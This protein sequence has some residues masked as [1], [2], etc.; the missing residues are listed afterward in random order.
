MELILYTNNNPFIRSLIHKVSLM[1]Q[2]KQP[3]YQGL[4]PK[5]ETLLY[6]S[7]HPNSHNESTISVQKASHNQKSNTSQDEKQYKILS[8]VLVI[9]LVVVLVLIT[10]IAIT[11]L[12]LALAN[13][14]CNSEGDDDTREEL[15]QIG[16][17]NAQLMEDVRLLTTQVRGALMAENC[18]SGVES[19]CNI[20]ALNDN[21]CITPIVLFNRQD[22][23]VLGFSCFFF[24][25]N[26]RL[27]VVD[28]DIM[29]TAVLSESNNVASCYCTTSSSIRDI[30]CG[31]FVTRCKLT[32]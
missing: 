9:V 20:T 15:N 13:R 19:T 32:N 17:N 25:R 14:S 30:R 4:G 8:G 1:L 11:A 21:E 16:A 10:V 18:T 23:I 26:A 5:N 3:T 22:E 2:S 29:A 6:T 24:P 27:R 7:Y 12:A 28:G 31:L